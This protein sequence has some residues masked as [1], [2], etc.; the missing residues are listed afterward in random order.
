MD[1]NEFKKT[2]EHKKVVEN[3][4]QVTQQP[5]VSVCVQTYQHVNYIKQCLDSILSQQTNFEFEILLGDD[6]SSDG[7]REICIKYAEKHP[8]KI[9][10]FLHHRENN[11]KIAGQPTGRFNFLYNLYSS[12]GNYIALCEG[13]DY[14]TDPLKLQKQVDFLEA[15]PDYIITCHNA[16]VINEKG[17][18]T[19]E[20]KLQKQASNKT[21]SQIDLKK[22]AHLLTLTMMFRNIDFLEKFL[23]SFYSVLNADTYLISCLGFY[24]KGMFL[25]NIKD[26]SYRVHEGGIWSKKQDFTKFSN[27]VRLFESLLDL[28]IY[29][30]SEAEVITYFKKVKFIYKE[31]SLMAANKHVTLAN[32]SKMLKKYVNDEKYNLILISKAI[33]FYII[34]QFK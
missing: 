32:F 27:L 11:I 12:Q 2:Y 9:R 21:Y 7:T 34:R 4:N 29:H 30:N 28:H 15:N 17:I 5:V 33:F 26:A 1:I 22:G 10:L 14:W 3:D 31:K 16:K 18:I 8:D 23:P 6:A 20:K 13:D 25:S 19:K 24:G